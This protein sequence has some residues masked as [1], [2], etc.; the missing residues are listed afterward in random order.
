MNTIEKLFVIY[1][2]ELRNFNFNINNCVFSHI[3]IQVIMWLSVRPYDLRPNG[4][5]HKWLMPLPW[6][7]KVLPATTENCCI[8]TKLWN[9]SRTA[10]ISYK[11]VKQVTINN[12]YIILNRLIGRK[13]R[14]GERKNLM[15]KIQ[16]LV[17][18]RQPMFFRIL[19]VSLIVT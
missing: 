6:F 19:I 2:C 8:L 4:L 11:F 18:C 16:H 9:Q 15:K 7:T 14:E 12:S 10:G 3:L 1:T 5:I 13:R 17:I